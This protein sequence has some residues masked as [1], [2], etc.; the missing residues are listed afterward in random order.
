MII[1][2]FIVTPFQQNARI[3]ACE[4][5]GRAICIDPGDEAARI[6]RA[7]DRNNLTLQAI[8]LTHAHMDHIG[9]VGALKRLKS[10]AEIIL[11]HADEEIY[12]ALP[13][14]PAWL[15]LPREAWRMLGVE[16]DAPPAVDRYWTE[17]EVYAV[18]NLRF[19]ILHCPGHSPGHVALF[20]R[21]ERK[22]FAGDCLFAGS[23]GRTDLAG[24]S[25]DELL[26]TIANKIIP[27]GDDVTVYTGHG[28]ATTIGHERHTN[29]F[30]T[31]TPAF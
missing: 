18:G 31:G 12:H 4:K 2:E 1:E 29:P 20:E 24:G 19:E 15:G 6:A 10:D 13:E 7:L 30:L 28:P 11:H 5:T 9:A 25:M 17:G 22:L 21:R 27:L 16:Y 23:I 8:A 14:Q 3:V 26:A